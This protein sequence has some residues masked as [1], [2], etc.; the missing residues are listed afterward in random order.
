MHLGP[1]P[2]VEAV[3]SERRRPEVGEKGVPGTDLFDKAEMRVVRDRILAETLHGGFV[4]PK[5]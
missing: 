5:S 1:R 4:V 2:N 3:P